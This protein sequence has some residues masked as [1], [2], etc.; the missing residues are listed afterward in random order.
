[1]STTKSQ[2]IILLLAL[3]M[4]QVSYQAACNIPGCDGCVNNVC[5]SCRGA[6]K[7]FPQLNTAGTC[8]PCPTGCDSCVRNASNLICTRCSDAA[9]YPKSGSTTCEKCPEGCDGC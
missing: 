8:D 4:A 3:A 5:I 6:A 2:A 7:Y 9:S 1:M